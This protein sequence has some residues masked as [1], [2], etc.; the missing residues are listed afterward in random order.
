MA[1]EFPENLNRRLHCRDADVGEAFDDL[2]LQRLSHTQVAPGGC[3]AEHMDQ[4]AV[5]AGNRVPYVQID[6]QVRCAERLVPSWVVVV[7]GYPREA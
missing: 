6:D 4:L 7:F 2:P 1:F 3:T 5:R